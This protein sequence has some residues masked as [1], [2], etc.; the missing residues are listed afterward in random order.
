VTLP[1]A[2]CRSR[3]RPASSFGQRLRLTAAALLLA[4]CSP[5]LDFRDV[6]AADGSFVIALP[7]RPQVATR[8]LEMPAGKVEMTMTS[9]GVGRT[10]FAVGVAPLPQAA[11]APGEVSTTLAWFR[12]GLLRNLGADQAGLLIAQDLQVPA[13]LAAGRTVRG[14]QSLSARGP[15]GADGRAVQLAARFYVV[16]DRLYQV[17]AM[18]AEGEIPALAQ[19]TFF[20]SFRLLR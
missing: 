3:V 2:E 12:T 10:L 1:R 18:G 19:E 15:A 17:V 13:Q 9:A 6:R 5:A 4:G 16:D 8:T 11:Y 7:G 14:A 20:A